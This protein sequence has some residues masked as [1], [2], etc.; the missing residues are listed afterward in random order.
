[1]NKSLSTSFTIIIYVLLL[2]TSVFFIRF[3]VNIHVF[4]VKFQ[5]DVNDSKKYWYCTL[6]LM[7]VGDDKI[8]G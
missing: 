5:Q 1:M 4:M 3:V 8:D 7:L 6:S 2:I